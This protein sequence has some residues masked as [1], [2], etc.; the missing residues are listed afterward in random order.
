MNMA[1]CKGAPIQCGDDELTLLRCYLL[2]PGGQF[3]HQVPRRSAVHLWV[4]QRNS[5]AVHTSMELRCATQRWTAE[6][7]GT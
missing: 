2:L 5:M 1:K 3:P 6:R 7:R 4:A